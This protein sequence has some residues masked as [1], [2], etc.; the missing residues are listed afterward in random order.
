MSRN[1]K[2]TLL[3]IMLALAVLIAAVLWLHSRPNKNAMNDKEL[4]AYKNSFIGVLMAELDYAD[5]ERAV[6]HYGSGLFVY[7]IQAQELEHCID[8]ST[9]ALAPH[10]NGSST[11]SVSVSQDGKT[12][13]L[14]SIG[15]EEE[16]EKFQNYLVDLDSGRVQKT[17]QKQLAEPFSGYVMTTDMVPSPSG[18]CSGMAV[19]QGSTVYYLTVEGD[20]VIGNVQLVFYDTHSGRSYSHQPLA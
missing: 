15:P 1:I 8:L 10:Q 2:R 11:L 3:L 9:L 17:W 6:F 20:M 12:A 5:K 14:S 4:A 13:Y 18:W 7:N 19:Q 16:I